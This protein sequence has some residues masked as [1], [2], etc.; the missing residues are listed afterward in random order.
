MDR[1]P[2]IAACLFPV[3]CTER[4]PQHHL[5][6]HSGKKDH[7]C[8]KPGVHPADPDG[9]HRVRTKRSDPGHICQIVRRRK[10][11]RRHN[12]HGKTRERREDGLTHQVDLSSSVV[13]SLLCHDPII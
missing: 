9:G 2:G 12:G 4:L 8:G 7:S 13:L 10:E 11:G 1:S 6:A 3:S 5:S